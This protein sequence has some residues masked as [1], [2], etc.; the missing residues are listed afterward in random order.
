MHTQSKWSMTVACLV[1]TGAFLG[2]N[3]R[4]DIITFQLQA[5]KGTSIEVSEYPAD[6]NDL[7]NVLSPFQYIGPGN[8]GTLPSNQKGDDDLNNIL[9]PVHSMLNGDNLVLIGTV[10]ND[11]TALNIETGDNTPTKVHKTLYN[12]NIP[13]WVCG[14][15][16]YGVRVPAKFRVQAIDLL[17][18]DAMKQGYRIILYPR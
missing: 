8:N 12:A 2:S 3:I 5:P 11:I 14:S 13:S 4:A 18:A 10:A 1:L 7:D 15:I 17:R 16:F 9:S 6:K